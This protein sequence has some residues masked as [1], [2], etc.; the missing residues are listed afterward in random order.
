MMWSN[1]MWAEEQK[2]R[3]IVRHVE[4]SFMLQSTISYIVADDSVAESAPKAVGLT[5]AI[6]QAQ[7]PTMSVKKNP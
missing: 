4:G 3:R 5:A 2:F 1:C 7:K 6:R